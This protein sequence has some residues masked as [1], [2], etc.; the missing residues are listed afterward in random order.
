MGYLATHVAAHA[1]QANASPGPQVPAKRSKSTSAPR[2]VA[3]RTSTSSTVGRPDAPWEPDLERAVER[4]M[5]MMKIPGTSG[6]E[7]E[8]ADYIASRLQAAGVPRGQIKFDAAHK[9]SPLGG[10]LGNMV[11]KLPGTQ[12]APR[13]MLS[14]HLDTVPICVGSIP[15]RRGNIV[16]SSAAGR[17]LGADNRAGCAV[18]LSA[19]LEILE[20]KL[21][22]P[23][24]TVCWFVQEEVG[25]QGARAANRTLW[26]NPKLAFNWDGG[27]PTKLTIGA[28]GGYRSEIRIRGIASHAGNAP[29]KG[30][31]AIAIAALAIADL[32]ENGWHG[33]VRKGTQQGTSNVGIIRG[34][35]ATNV[36]TEQVYV[37]AEARSH[38]PVFRKKILTQIETAFRRAAKAVRNVSGK[39]GHVTIASQLDYESFL[40]PSDAP[41]VQVAQAAVRAVGGEPQLAVA[42]GGV[43]ANWMTAH[44]LPTVSLG[45]GQRFQHMETETLNIAQFGL[46]CR[47]GLRLAT[48]TEASRG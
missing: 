19:V 41:C 24:L 10:Q 48:G 6:Q 34:G 38:D 46:A 20:R 44:G 3:R 43:D 25:L 15:T 35:D 4:V 21:P 22:Y 47:I 23:P 12:R 1:R 27:A 5:E 18:L 36:V 42:N 8:I 13:R 29:E 37:K 17:G 11:L 39:A 14:A 26:G 2:R 45:C 9:R 31:S 32:H 40:L 28:T 30:V 16:R 33:D 7:T